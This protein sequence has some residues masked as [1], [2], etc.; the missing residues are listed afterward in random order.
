MRLY[1]SVNSPFVRKVRIV[2]GEL[3]LEERVEFIAAEGTPLDDPGLRAK[4]PLKKIP[5]LETSDERILFDSRVI[6]EAMIESCPDE[7]TARAMLPSGGPD[8][9]D[10]LTRQALGDGICDAAVGVAYETR[11]RP[12]ALHWPEWLDIQWGK[13]VSALDWAETRA[14]AAD[15]FDLG[16]AALAAALPYLD[17]RFPDRDWRIGRPA[18]TGWWDGVRARPAVAATLS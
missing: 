13:V 18:L 10:T 15:R 17:F 11:L 5:F 1:G 6:A 4:T 14:L 7:A 2:I 16:D 9:Q 12:E 3:E 8:R